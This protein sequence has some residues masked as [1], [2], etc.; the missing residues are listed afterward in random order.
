MLLV[1]FGC[2]FTV[3]AGISPTDN[4]LS[5]LAQAYN[6]DFLNLGESGNSNFG[7]GQNFAHFI[8][9]EKHMYNNIAVVVGWTE[10]DRMSWWDD[11]S[12]H[13]VH[14]GSVAYAKNSIFIEIAGNRFLG[15]CKEWISYSQGGEA[16]GNQ[17]FTDTSK[18]LVNSVCT[19]NNIP[20]LQFNSLG[21]HHTYHNY[22]NY[23]LP[24][25]NTKD[26]LSKSDYIPNDGH[27]NEQ[28]HKKIADRLINFAKQCKIF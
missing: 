22:L 20:I 24:D 10:V 12:H 5:L 8:N 9:Y 23:Y 7:I 19:A 3:G 16:S 13:W 2:S 15:S 14:S 25:K 18:L 4:W 26:Y 28:G 21:T 17:A 11:E 27:P 1:G 6:C